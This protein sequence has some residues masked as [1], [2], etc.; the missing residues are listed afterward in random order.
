M[1]FQHN[2]TI[3]AGTAWISIF[4][5][6]SDNTVISRFLLPL[7]F[8]GILRLKE[9]IRSLDQCPEIRQPGATVVVAVELKKNVDE[10]NPDMEPNS[11]FLCS[12]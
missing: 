4:L 12:P 7:S 10:I 11:Y 9:Q 8:T 6:R 5:R 1:L 3:H 2:K